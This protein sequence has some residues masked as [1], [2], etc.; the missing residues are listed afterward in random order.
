MN[1]AKKDERTA[2]SRDSLLA[3]APEHSE[4]SWQVPRVV[5]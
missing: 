1:N 3:V 2:I 4:D 5:K